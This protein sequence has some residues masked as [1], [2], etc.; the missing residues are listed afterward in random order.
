[1]ANGWQQPQFNQINLPQGQA[2]NPGAVNAVMANPSDQS[3]LQQMLNQAAQQHQ[4][5]NP[6]M[7]FAM[8]GG[9][10]QPQ[11][12]QQQPWGLPPLLPIQPGG[13]Q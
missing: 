2:A 4:Q 1:M 8:Q 6:A 10:Q 7:Q 11:G 3:A 12:Q 5:P 13:V 9:Q